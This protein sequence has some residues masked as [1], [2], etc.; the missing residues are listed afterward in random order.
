MQQSAS[1]IEGSERHD[2]RRRLIVGCKNDATLCRQFQSV[3]HLRARIPHRQTSVGRPRYDATRSN[4]AALSSV[5]TSCFM[6]LD[7][8][9]K[10]LHTKREGQHFDVRASFLLSATA[11]PHNFTPRSK[12]FNS[13]R[14]FVCAVERPVTVNVISRG[15]IPFK[16]NDRTR[17]T[18]ILT[19][20]GPQR[21]LTQH[22]S[23]T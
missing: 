3:P 8:Y 12:S 11:R 4:S 14:H 2:R 16:T 17:R 9:R 5:V 10:D 23:V 15:N 13:L 19:S 20:L 7:Q 21:P 22:P 18:S 1:H 6:R